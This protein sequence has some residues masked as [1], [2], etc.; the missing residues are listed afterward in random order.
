[1]TRRAQNV[2]IKTLFNWLVLGTVAPLSSG[3]VAGE[4]EARCC[5]LDWWRS[6]ARRSSN[7]GLYEEVFVSAMAI[8]RTRTLKC[9][10]ATFDHAEVSWIF[11]LRGHSGTSSRLS[12]GRQ[13]LSACSILMQTLVSFKD[14][15]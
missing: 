9:K 8:I 15:Q 10:T 7:F 3:S 4:A 1:M 2:T 13:L 6:K 14:R 11:A 5:C 12:Q